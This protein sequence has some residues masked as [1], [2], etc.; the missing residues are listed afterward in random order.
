M[1]EQM[2]YRFSQ[3]SA[4]MKSLLGGKGANLS[5]MTR[6]GLPVPPGFVITT[7]ACNKYFA[8]GRKIWPEL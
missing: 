3:G 8:E 2:V 7:E 6:I 1:S 5:E 4:E